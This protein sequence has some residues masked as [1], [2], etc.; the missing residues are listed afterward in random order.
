MKKGMYASGVRLEPVER[1]WN[2]LV[3][4]GEKRDEKRDLCKWSS[5]GAS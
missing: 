4:K 3:S 5:A 2:Q 1:S